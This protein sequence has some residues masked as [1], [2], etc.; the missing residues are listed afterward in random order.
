MGGGMDVGILQ[1][2][3]IPD[4]TYELKGFFFNTF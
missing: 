1:D 2:V 3:R 4:V